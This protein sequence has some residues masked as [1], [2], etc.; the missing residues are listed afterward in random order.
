MIRILSQCFTAVLALLFFVTPTVADPIGTAQLS[1][2]DQGWA[3][4][5]SPVRIR[6]DFASP[7]G[8]SPWPRFWTFL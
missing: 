1:S 8:V 3:N 7:F 2:A 6:I 5:F 4:V